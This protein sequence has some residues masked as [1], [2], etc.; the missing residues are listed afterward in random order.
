MVNFGSE[1][2]IFFKR[3]GKS[4]K[5]WEIGDHASGEFTTIRVVS[6]VKQHGAI[7]GIGYKN[8]IEAAG[9]FFGLD[10]TDYGERVV[11]NVGQHLQII[12]A[13]FFFPG[14]IPENFVW[15]QLAK[16]HGAV[17]FMRL[18]D[19]ILSRMGNKTIIRLGLAAKVP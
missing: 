8:H 11:V 7:L 5:K 15:R 2:A 3:K 18:I 19:L 10:L 17:P 16:R 14:P 1:V 4:R 9:D 13:K 6:C 12:D